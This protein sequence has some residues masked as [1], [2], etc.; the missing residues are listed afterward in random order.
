MTG[1]EATCTKCGNKYVRLPRAKSGLCCGC[2]RL[3]REMLATEKRPVTDASAFQ[4]QAAL[5]EWHSED[6]L[7]CHICGDSF[8]GLYRHVPMVHGVTTRD[9]KMRLASR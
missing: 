4:T 2:R 7:R 9:Y 3:K 6:K 5:V 8:A 1:V